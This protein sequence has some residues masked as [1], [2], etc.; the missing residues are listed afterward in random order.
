MRPPRPS[1]L[2]LLTLKTEQRAGSSAPRRGAAK[3]K[4]E[5]PRAK[6]VDAEMELLERWA[7]VHGFGGTLEANGGDNKFYHLAEDDEGSGVAREAAVAGGRSSR[8]ESDS[9]GPASDGEEEGTQDLTLIAQYYVVDRLATRARTMC[10][11]A[12]LDRHEARKFVDDIL[13]DIRHSMMS[14]YRT[15]TVAAL[16]VDVRRLSE[17]AGRDHQ[18]RWNS[19]SSSDDESGARRPTAAEPASPH[20]RAALRRE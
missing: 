10:R 19:D 17:H 15:F 5:H 4:I 7:V 8:D 9:E 2:N 18:R 11:K 14:D 12:R 1:P 3:K 13:Y 6:S 16:S 20:P